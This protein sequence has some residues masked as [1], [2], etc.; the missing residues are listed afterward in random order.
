M[1]VQDVSRP[2]LCWGEQQQQQ[3]DT[4]VWCCSTQ[5]RVCFGGRS[6]E[7]RMQVW[8][9]LHLQPL[10]LQQMIFYYPYALSTS[11]LCH[12]EVSTY[13]SAGCVFDNNKTCEVAMI[14]TLSVYVSN[15]LSFNWF[16]YECLFILIWGVFLLCFFSYF[17][18]KQD[19]SKWLWF[20]TTCF[21]S[22]Y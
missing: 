5:E 4:C 9:K 18:S 16:M 19:P 1:Q 15:K 14:H 21:I 17:I 22:Q 20:E 7:W 10:H 2:E 13:V 12:V 11:C 8:I 3:G 6:R